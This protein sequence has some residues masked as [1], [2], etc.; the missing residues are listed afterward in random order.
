MF[1]ELRQYR[2]KKGGMKEW[3]A[4]M[5]SLI[6]PFQVSRGMVI[7][8]S[9]VDEE[10]P[11]QYVWMRRFKSEAERK[12]LYQRVYETAT[13]KEEISPKI[14]KLL[15]RSTIK[16]TRLVPTAKSPVQ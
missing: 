2:I 6:I 13:W 3:V 11:T 14:G 7:T 16:V 9:F 15:D 12:R 10:D 5:E 1:Y 4:L 8:A